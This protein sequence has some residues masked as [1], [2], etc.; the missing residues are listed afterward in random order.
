MNRQMYP[1]I[2]NYPSDLPIK[3][4]VW[5]VG[6]YPYH[7]HDALEVVYILRGSITINLSEETHSLGEKMIAVI[8]TNEI[9]RIESFDDKNRILI[10]QM[11]R[12]WCEKL[13]PDFEYNFFW[14][15][16]TYSKNDDQC[17]YKRFID[18]LLSLVR[19]MAQ[20]STKEILE[21]RALALLEHAAAN[22]DFIRC[23][24]GFDAISEKLHKRIKQM[25]KYVL[26]HHYQVSLKDL[27]QQFGINL[28]HMSLRLKSNSAFL[29]RTY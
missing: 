7:W 17:N 13:L 15:C 3:A 26:D 23:G 28:F 9:H 2:I 1:E 14:C 11:D 25:Y 29:T 20:H 10:V 4:V 12:A 21:L 5:S 19:E 16:S 22:F 8:N 18:L 27:A 6:H 24:P